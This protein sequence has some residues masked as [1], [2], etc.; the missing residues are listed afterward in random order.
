MCVAARRRGRSV[1][2]HARRSAARR[3]ELGA[4]VWKAWQRHRHSEGRHGVARGTGAGTLEAPV[5][6]NCRRRLGGPHRRGARRAGAARGVAPML[7]ITAPHAAFHQA[8]GDPRGRSCPS[9]SSQR[10]RADRRRPSAERRTS[11]ANGPSSIGAASRSSAGTVLELFPI[12]R[13]RRRSSAAWAGIE[14]RMPDDHSGDRAELDREGVFHGFGFSRPWLPAR[15]RRGRHDG[16]ADRQRRH[17][18]ADRRSRYRPLS[19]FHTL[20]PR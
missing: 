20:E 6:V 11:D 17:P 10:H 13:A 19:S 12:M 16:R 8:G 18:D 9:S 15:P 3:R 14:A 5:L 7:M 1:P 4:T 2:H